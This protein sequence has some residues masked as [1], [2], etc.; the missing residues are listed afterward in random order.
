M[1]F[2]RETMKQIEIFYMKVFVTSFR[3]DMA[4]FVLCILYDNENR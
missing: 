4:S 3:F 1:R 2:V